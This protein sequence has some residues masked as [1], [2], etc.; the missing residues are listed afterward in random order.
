MDGWGSAKSLCVG[1]R[2]ST[3]QG[4]DSQPASQ[5]AS[6]PF[7]V[8]HVLLHRIY[9]YHF[10]LVLKSKFQMENGLYALIGLFNMERCTSG[11]ENL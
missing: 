8:Q 3:V 10:G 11:I 9:Y 6:E 1:R 2:L 4:G 7:Y 5:P